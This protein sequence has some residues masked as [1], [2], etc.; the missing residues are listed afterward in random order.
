MNYQSRILTQRMTHFE[1][2]LIDFDV[3]YFG[4]EGSPYMLLR[5]P[6]T[7]YNDLHVSNFPEV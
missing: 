4:E 7:P 2:D 5:E 6:I 3:R 1:N